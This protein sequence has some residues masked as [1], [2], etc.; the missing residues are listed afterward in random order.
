MTQNCSDAELLHVFRCASV[1]VYT[2]VVESYTKFMIT[3][4]FFQIC[5]SDVPGLKLH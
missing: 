4:T 1:C 5:A 3:I 2:G